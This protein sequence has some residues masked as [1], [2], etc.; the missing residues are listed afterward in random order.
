[1]ILIIVKTRIKLIKK[2]KRDRE[3]NQ[4]KGDRI[5]NHALSLLSFRFAPP[6]NVP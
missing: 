2:I 5:W 6:P 3:Q 4:N 1:M